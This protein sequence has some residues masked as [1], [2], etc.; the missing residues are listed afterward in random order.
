MPASAPDTD[1]D[2]AGTD[3]PTYP[4]S[5]NVLEPGC[6]RCSVLADSRE[7]I[8]WGTGDLDASIVVVGEAPGR[9]T[10]DADRWRGGNWT[11]KAYTSRHS[12]RRIRR[13]VADIGY[14]DDAYYTNAVKCVP[15]DPTDPTS[16]REP[17]PEE[18]TNCRPHLLTELETVDP[19]TSDLLY[20]KLKPVRTNVFAHT[21]FA[22]LRE[23]HDV[24]DAVFPINGAT[25]L[26]DACSR[27]SLDFSNE[28]YHFRTAF[29]TPK[30]KLLMSG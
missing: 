9:G 8:S 18:R 29:V 26:Q 21:F 12:G 14:G 27:H 13:L 19:E 6:T 22:E 2:S 20:T 11:G 28:L 4:T 16:N 23:K 1:P 5:R 17:T 24:D 30:Q 3:D 10:P 7:C 25:P 15:V